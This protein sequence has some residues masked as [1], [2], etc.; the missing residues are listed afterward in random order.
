MIRKVVL[1]TVLIYHLWMD[2]INTANN[3]KMEI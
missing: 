1:I 3:K 2:T